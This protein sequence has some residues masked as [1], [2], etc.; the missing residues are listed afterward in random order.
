MPLLP[1][2]WESFK[3]TYDDAFLDAGRRLED[4][5]LAAARLGSLAE[6]AEPEAPRAA[7]RA[8]ADALRRDTIGAVR[9]LRELGESLNRMREGGEL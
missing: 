2:E 1:D 6:A 7:F 3:R 5:G 8:L 9:A 4:I